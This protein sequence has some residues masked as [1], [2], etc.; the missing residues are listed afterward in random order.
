MD[1]SVAPLGILSTYSLHFL[2]NCMLNV[3]VFKH[4]FD[5]HVSLFE[6]IVI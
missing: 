6:A 4:S 1:S 2:H 3:D 5:N